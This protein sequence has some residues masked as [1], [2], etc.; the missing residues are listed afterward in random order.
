MKPIDYE[1]MEELMSKE[2]L[3]IEEAK[4]LG[5]MRLQQLIH[6]EVAC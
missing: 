6:V 1:R 2:F 3:T 5:H 4:E